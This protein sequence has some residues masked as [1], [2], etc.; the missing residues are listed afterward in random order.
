M[1]ITRISM[2]GIAL[3]ATLTFG[4][5][6]MFAADMGL[7]SELKTAITHA[8]FAEKYETQK[9][10]TLHLHHV[11]NCLVGPNDKMFDGSAGNPCQGQGNGILADIKGSMGEDQQYQVAWWLAQLADKAISMGNLQQQHAAAHIIGTQLTSMQKM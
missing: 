9:E 5:Q 7:A 4:P 1:R 2:L 10:V 3:L 11:I 6:A 8:G